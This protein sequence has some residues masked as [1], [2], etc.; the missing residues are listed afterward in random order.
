L[1]LEQEVNM[2]NQP[3][4]PEDE[5]GFDPDSP[6]VEDPQVDPVGPAKAPDDGPDL[7]KDKRVGDDDY[8][9]YESDR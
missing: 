3:R 9:P 2:T 6:D 7:G 4:D 8:P 5:L 1:G